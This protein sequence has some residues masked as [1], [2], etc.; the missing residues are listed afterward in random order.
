M[1]GVTYCKVDLP[2]LPSPKLTPNGRVVIAC[3]CKDL[4]RSNPVKNKIYCLLFQYYR[5]SIILKVDH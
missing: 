2:P 4:A 3:K 1:G 5:N